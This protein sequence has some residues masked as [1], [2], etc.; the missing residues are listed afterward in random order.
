[1]LSERAY[2]AVASAVAELGLHTPSTSASRTAC[3]D[4]R[5][6]FVMKPLPTNP[7]PRRLGVLM[8]HPESHAPSVVAR[9]DL[10]RCTE[11]PANHAEGCEWN[12]DRNGE[13]RR[14][15]VRSDFA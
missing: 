11:L 13:G 9:D 8:T 3:H 10:A 12:E 2:A 15:S 14:I 7:T 6:N 5:W 4:C 1:M